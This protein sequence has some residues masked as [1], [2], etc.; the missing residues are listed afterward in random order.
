MT[1]AAL[2]L[3][4]V[5]RGRIHGAVANAFAAWVVFIGVFLIISGVRN[6]FRSELL[7]ITMGMLCVLGGALSFVSMVVSVR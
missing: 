6:G 4:E 1:V 2:V 7:K 5:V 3:P